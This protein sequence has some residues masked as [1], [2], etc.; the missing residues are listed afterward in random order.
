MNQ[1]V[2]RILFGIIG[3]TLIILDFIMMYYYYVNLYAKKDPLGIKSAVKSYMKEHGMDEENYHFDGVL[4]ESQNPLSLFSK[5]FF[6]LIFYVINIAY[7]L[8]AIL[9]IIIY[10]CGLCDEKICLIMCSIGMFGGQ[11][12]IGIIDICVA[13]SHPTLTQNELSNFGELNDSIKKTYD[14]YLESKLYAKLISFYLFFSPMFFL[15]TS[16][17]QLRKVK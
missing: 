7:L 13:F 4:W 14:L 10:N 16:L 6:G 8:T 5:F 2:K 12:F 17:L 9:G 1:K 11:I 3:T 15:V